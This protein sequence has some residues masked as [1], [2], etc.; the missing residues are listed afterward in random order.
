MRTE[1]RPRTSAR[2]QRGLAM[3]EF[4]VTA[5]VLLLLLFVTVE[6]GHFITEYSTLNDAVRNAARYVAG[7][8][9]Q[10]TTG[11]LSQ[12]SAWSAI[13]AQGKNLAVFGNVSGSGTALLPSL[14]VAEI[15][16]TEDTVNSNITVAAA[17]PYDSLF[18]ASLPNFFGGSIATNW[19]LSISTTMKAI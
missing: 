8:A 17:Y 11:L 2:R 3:V 4:A 19:V 13:V 10:G 6:L 1:R 9:L 14:T 7:S 12:G 15:M 16:V 5:P 18:G